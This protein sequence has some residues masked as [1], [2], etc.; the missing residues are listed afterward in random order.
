MVHPSGFG[1]LVDVGPQGL[2]K[3]L[4]GGSVGDV[5]TPTTHH[6]LKERGRAEWRSVEEDLEDQYKRV[7][8]ITY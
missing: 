1:S 8:E 4:E 3:S 7:N 5:A 2:V 6:Q